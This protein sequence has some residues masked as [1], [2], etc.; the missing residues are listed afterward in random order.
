[1]H[2]GADTLAG[3]FPH[4]DIHRSLPGYRLPMAFRR[5]L[6]PSSPLDA[7]SSAMRPYW[8]DHP[9][10]TPT[11]ALATPESER[12]VYDRP[13][14]TINGLLG[15]STRTSETSPRHGHQLKTLRLFSVRHP[16]FV[17]TRKTVSDPRWGPLLVVMHLSERRVLPGVR[18]SSPSLAPRW[19]GGDTISHQDAVKLPEPQFRQGFA[20]FRLRG[21]PEAGGASGLRVRRHEQ[22]GRRAGRRLSGLAQG[23]P[24]GR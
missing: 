10:R 2:S 1:M 22:L 3:G 6:R 8:F 13:A 15:R 18:R 20:D 16:T 21:P 7:K 23:G 11:A 4:S 12:S 24:R 17:G 14:A 9:D 19:G 5:F